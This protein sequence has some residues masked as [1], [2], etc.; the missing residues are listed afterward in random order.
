[1]AEGGAG[2]GEGILKVY[3]R[4]YSCVFIRHIII[5][6]S[7]NVYMLKKHRKI[8]LLAAANLDLDVLLTNRAFNFLLK[9]AEAKKCR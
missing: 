8:K 4:V 6:T 9:A 5:I 3:P 2:G 1:M 7:I